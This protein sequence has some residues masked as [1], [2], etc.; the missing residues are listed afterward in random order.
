MDFRF[1]HRADVRERLSSSCGSRTVVAGAVVVVVTTFVVTGLVR[2]HPYADDVTAATAAGDDWLS[3]KLYA[4]S[5]LDG[6]LHIPA[7]PGAYYLPGGFLYNYF[8][9]AV[10]AIFGTSTGYVY[11]VQYA[12]LG[13]AASLMFIFARGFLSSDV[14]LGYF[15]TCAIA[16]YLSFGDYVHRLLSEN[17]VVVL[18]PVLLISFVRALEQHS[19]PRIALA[20][21]IAGLVV[22]TRP[23][24][25]ILPVLLACVLVLFDRQK[26]SLGRAALFLTTTAAAFSL[27]PLRNAYVTG[28]LVLTPAY[29]VLVPD[30][31]AFDLAAMVAQRLLFCVGIMIGGW[32]SAGSEIVVNKRLL[33]LN[34]GAAIATIALIAR[35][36]FRYGDAICVATVAAAYGP[37][38]FLPALGG[39]GFRFQTPYVP[40]LLLLVFRGIDEMLIGFRGPRLRSQ[41]ERRS[42]LTREARPTRG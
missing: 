34:A 40:V 30:G 25:V 2:L 39:Y 16:L 31:S 28:A 9:A 37:F 33:L 41:P 23:N 27:L 36:R 4:V 29:S 7:V 42:S 8:V 1:L 18:Y 26:G 15:V 3:Y 24:L 10:F 14:A 12:L 22:L 21:F 19:G 13:I 17:L 38:A 20:G 5:I 11:V 32:D 35:Q 6:G